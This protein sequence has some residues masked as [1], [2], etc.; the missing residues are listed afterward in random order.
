[1]YLTYAQRK[2]VPEFLTGTGE[3]FR[4]TTSPVSPETKAT[5]HLPAYKKAMQSCE[6]LIQEI[7]PKLDISRQAAVDISIQF[8]RNHFPDDAKDELLQLACSR[9][10]GKQQSTLG[11]MVSPMLVNQA[12]FILFTVFI[13]VSVDVI[14][15]KKKGEA[16]DYHSQNHA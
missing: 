10:E 11:A 16:T 14:H 15:R 2:G 7:R 5:Y 12:I 4:E 13:S 1:M 8:I 3:L 6:A 9:K